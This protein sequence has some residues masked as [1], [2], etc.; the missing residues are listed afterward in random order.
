MPRHKHEI[1][2]KKERT[3]GCMVWVRVK[4]PARMDSNFKITISSWDYCKR[5]GGDRRRGDIWIQTITD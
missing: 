3:C 5:H 2:I 4:I 1:Q